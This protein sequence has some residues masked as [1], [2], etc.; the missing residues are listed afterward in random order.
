MLI[1][2]AGTLNWPTKTRRNNERSPRALCAIGVL[3]LFAALMMPPMAGAADEYSF[4]TSETDK[5]PYSFGGYAEAKPMLFDLDRDAALYKTRFYD[6]HV[7][8]PLSEYDFT[9]QLDAGIEWNIF[10]AFARIN[11]SLDRTYDG[12][13]DDSK[14][15]EL[16][17]AAKPTPSLTASAGKLTAKWG[18]GYAWNPVAFLDRPKDPDD[19]ALNLEGYYMAGFDYIRSLEGPLKTFSLSPFLLPVDYGLNHDFGESGHLNYAAKAYFL[20]WDTDIDLMFLTGNS[21]PDRVGFDFSRNITT[22]LEIHGESAWIDDLQRMKVDSNGRVSESEIDAWSG[23][24]GLR[25][26][27]S[28]DTTYILEYYHNG[29]G[30]SEPEAKDYYSFVDQAYDAYVNTGNAGPIQKAANLTQGGYGRPNPMQDY[31]YFRVS[32][33]EPFDLLYFTPAITTILN[34]DDRSFSLSPELLYTGI[35]NLELR[36][37]GTVLIGDNFSEY[38]EKPNDARLELRVRYYF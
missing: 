29:S 38:G 13:S 6:R 7:S 5:K 17:L 1:T 35:T 25:Y 18:K 9:L 2:R 36:L 32:Q 34:L 8:N 28:I 27:T 19:P 31:L 4:D 21:R 11:N 37:K 23:L 16:F 33:K 3:L 15:Y 12:W 22:N 30:Y 24:L 14:P 20:L 10:K 26:L